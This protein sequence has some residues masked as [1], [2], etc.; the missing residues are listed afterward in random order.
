MQVLTGALWL[1]WEEQAVGDHGGSCGARKEEI[2]LI[3]VSDNG[4]KLGRE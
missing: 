1:L 2:V 4:D 3:P